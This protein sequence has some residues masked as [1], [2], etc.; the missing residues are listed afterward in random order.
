MNLDRLDKL[1][2]RLSSGLALGGVVLVVLLLAGVLYL[3]VVLI[4]TL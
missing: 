4:A 3:L 2:E 1:L